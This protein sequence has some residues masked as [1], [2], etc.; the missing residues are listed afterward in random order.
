MRIVSHSSLISLRMGS[1]PTDHKRCPPRWWL[2][3]SH[4]MKLNLWLWCHLFSWLLPYF[5]LACWIDTWPLKPSHVFWGVGP[6]THVG[7]HFVFS[8]KRWNHY[9]ARRN[10]H[11]LNWSIRFANRY[12]GSMHTA[13]RHVGLDPNTLVMMCTDPFYMIQRLPVRTMFTWSGL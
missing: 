4:K 6:T 5:R 13:C 8:S 1:Y 11:Y 12:V 7:F 10:H 2:F 3:V 9:W